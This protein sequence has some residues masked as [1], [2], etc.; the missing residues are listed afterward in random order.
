MPT[1]ITMLRTVFADQ[2]VAAD[3]RYFSQT[4]D[5]TRYQYR[6]WTRMA[7]LPTSPF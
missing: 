4:K 7:N 2:E 1:V 5:T 6:Q 3:S